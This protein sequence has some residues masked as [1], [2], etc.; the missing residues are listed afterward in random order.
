MGIR[1]ALFTLIL[2]SSAIS[3]AQGL[4]CSYLLKGQEERY[5]DLLKKVEYRQ[6]QKLKVPYIDINSKSKKTVVLVAGFSKSM[7][8]WAEQVE[9][10][11]SQGYRV[12]SMENFN[13]GLNLKKNGLVKL[14]SNEGINFDAVILSELIKRLK[15]KG[16]L[17]MVGHSRGAAVAAVATEAL[18]RQGRTVKSLQLMSPYVEYIWETSSMPSSSLSWIINTY[19]NLVGI[20]LDQGVKQSAADDVI[21]LD[22]SERRRGYAYVLK[23]LQPYLGDS[24]KLSESLN[25]LSLESRVKIQVFGVQNDGDFSPVDKIVELASDGVEVFVFD[26]EAKTHYWPLEESA[27]VNSLIIQ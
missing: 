12:I 17:R 4:S 15:P 21:A 20:S 27:L 24:Y 26:D 13:I 14:K 25:F 10:L 23:G 5:L 3:S 2:I 22:N 11:V 9:R 18:V 1:L 19:P 8:T 16:S 6:I 7:L